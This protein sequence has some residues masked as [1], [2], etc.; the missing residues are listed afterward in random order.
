MEIN[1]YDKHYQEV[2]ENFQWLVWFDN[3]NM[4][5]NDQN[6]M[7]QSPFFLYKKNISLVFSGV[8]KF[9]NLVTSIKTAFLQ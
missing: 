5:A 6:P 2:P 4:I 3:R 8:I 7:L 9:Y 1:I